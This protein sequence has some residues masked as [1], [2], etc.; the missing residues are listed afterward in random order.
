MG[1]G[2]LAN[3]TTGSANVALGFV[4]G[5]GVTTANNVIAIGT[6]GAN[7]SNSC[8]IGRIYSNVQ[9]QIGTDPDD[10]NEQLCGG[11]GRE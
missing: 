9:P 4:A 1:T 11:I 2:A 7:I 5:S 10:E 3:N 8:Y 6:H